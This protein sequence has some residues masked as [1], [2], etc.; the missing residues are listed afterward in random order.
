M[1]PLVILGAAIG[2]E[3]AKSYFDYDAA[4]SRRHALDLQ[5]KQNQIQIQ[6]KTLANYDQVQKV[7]EAQEAAMTTR[8]VSFASPSYKAIAGEAYN[9]GAKTQKNINLEGEID[10]AN[11][12]IEKQNVK[13]TLFAQLFGNA[14]SVA[15]MGYSAYTAAPK[16]ASMD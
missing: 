4:K 9:V 16:L 1:L 6:Q 14:A 10:K 8:G 7:L 13:D 2:L 11:I 3:A 15:S 12:D 5:N